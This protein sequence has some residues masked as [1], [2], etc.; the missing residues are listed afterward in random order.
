MARY[1]VG[2]SRHVVRSSTEREFQAYD[3]LPK[4]LR[5]VLKHAP[6]C[7]SALE[8]STAWSQAQRMGVPLHAFVHEVNCLIELDR[9]RR[10]LTHAVT[11]LRRDRA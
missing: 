8:I 7:Y 5:D 4:T 11:D 10:S 1:N 2:P 6:Y 9:A 3:G